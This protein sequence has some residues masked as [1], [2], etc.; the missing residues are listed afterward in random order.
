MNATKARERGRQ[1]SASSNLGRDGVKARAGVERKVNSDKERLKKERVGGKVGGEGGCGL[2]QRSAAATVGN[3][4]RSNAG[5]KTVQK[6]REDR[7]K[8]VLDMSKFNSINVVI[9]HEIYVCAEK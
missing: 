9:E 2:Q 4:Q 6:A 5:T 7:K 1:L 3:G 8:A